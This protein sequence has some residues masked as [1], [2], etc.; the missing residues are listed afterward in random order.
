MTDEEARHWIDRLAAIPY[1]G[2]ISDILDESGYHHQAL[3][4]Q[5]Q[6]LTRGA[7]LA[8]R[9]MTVRGEKTA[10]TDPE[11][12]FIPF[13]A[14]LG[15]LGPGDVIVSQPNDNLAAHL[16]EL[17]AE[18]AQYRGARGAVIDGGVRDTSYIERLG[19]PVF[20]RYRT[21]IDIVGRWRLTGFG[22]PIEIGGVTVRRG[23]FVV[24]DDDGVLIIPYEVAPEVI[25]RAEEVIK[26]ENL[27][28]TDILK[29]VHPVEAFRRHGRF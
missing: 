7:T 17:S 19:F 22:D 2:A 8:G 11:E 20:A 4:Y 14:M 21:P 13:L 16:G 10:S 26:T 25:A 1:T 24:G 23:D 28:R 12:I 29:G 18:T 5:I 9:A 6:P 3:P 27:V 15:D